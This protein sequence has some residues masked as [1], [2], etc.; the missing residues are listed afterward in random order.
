MLRATH[1]GAPARRGIDA[2]GDRSEVT[3]N[4]DRF[5]AD[6][7]VVG[8]GGGGTED[9]IRLKEIAVRILGVYDL[10]CRAV[11]C[12]CHEKRT[13][14]RH[15]LEGEV[16]SRHF[17][18][19][20]GQ[21]VVLPIHV[22]RGRNVAQGI[23][24]GLI[25]V[26]GGVYRLRAI[27]LNVTDEGVVAEGAV[28]VL[29]PTGGDA[30]LCATAADEIGPGA[31]GHIQRTVV[32]DGEEGGH[33]VALCIE[34]HHLLSLDALIH[35]CLQLCLLGGV[36]LGAV[37][38]EGYGSNRIKEIVLDVF[39]HARGDLKPVIQHHVNGAVVLKLCRRQLTAIYADGVHGGGDGVE[40]GEAA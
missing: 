19:A 17:V 4:V 39:A 16:V 31:C 11:R 2:L 18:N 30:H 15:I 25:V 22:V 35:K 13:I 38:E 5:T 23:D 33:M 32:V 14:H 28:L 6:T 1:G 20:E 34:R 12:V 24:R 40:E 7:S 3:D 10:I 37:G 29:E 21:F 9:I 36:R 8:G 26:N 27:R